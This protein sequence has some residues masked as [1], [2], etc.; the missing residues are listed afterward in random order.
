[1]LNIQNAFCF[2]R[3]GWSCLSNVETCYR[4]L[5]WLMGLKVHSCDAV[6]VHDISCINLMQFCNWWLMKRWIACCLDVYLSWLV[7]NQSYRIFPRVRSS[8][9]W[10][11]SLFATCKLCL[12]IL[13]IHSNLHIVICHCQA[14]GLI[15]GFTSLVI[16]TVVRGSQHTLGLC[17]ILWRR[18]S[19]PL[20][21]EVHTSGC[22]WTKGG[23]HMSV[24]MHIINV[25]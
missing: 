4:I 10:C 19:A 16:F 18:L 3:A 5:P 17:N 25:Y 6:F 9:L 20:Q 15:L 12:H 8:V 2:S 21:Q 24:L 22:A 23:K 13:T 1:M 14:V 7:I 11:Y